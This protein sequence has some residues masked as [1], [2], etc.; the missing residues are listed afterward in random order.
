MKS[1]LFLSTLLCLLS[2]NKKNE[3]ITSKEVSINIIQPISLE[4]RASYKELTSPK[5]PKKWEMVS[6][7]N[8]EEV[9]YNPCNKANNQYEIQKKHGIWTLIETIDMN[10]NHYTILNTLVMDDEVA[11]ICKDFHNSYNGKIIFKIN[12]FNKEAKKCTWSVSTDNYIKKTLFINENG[13][14]DI[15]E[16]I[17]PC[18]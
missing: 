8:E 18:S 5:I 17:Q 11:I 10:I 12:D 1:I 2:C 3:K 14:D 4:N 16:I 7:I 6:V 13:K 9:I 15:T